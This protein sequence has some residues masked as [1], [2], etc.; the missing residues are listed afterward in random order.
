[1]S[2]EMPER[3]RHALGQLDLAPNAT[4]E[5]AK[6]AYHD[7]I[8]VWHPDKFAGRPKLLVRATQKTGQLNEA[9]SVLRTW[10]DAE[11]ERAECRR[12]AEHTQAGKDLERQRQSDAERHARDQDAARKRAAEGAERMRQRTAYADLR[13]RDQE[14]YDARMDQ[15][16]AAAARRRP[17][18]H[19][20][21]APSP[22]SGSS[23]RPNAD[24]GTA[25]DTSKNAPV[26]LSEAGRRPQRYAATVFV[27]ALGVSIPAFIWQQMI[28]ERFRTLASSTAP[29]DMAG[30]PYGLVAL[31]TCVCLIGIPTAVCSGVLTLWL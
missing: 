15:W 26:R 10:F 23:R 22:S 2:D 12:E 18:H 29:V 27:L 11:P 3:I 13:R 8:Q 14:A 21:N 4:R 5:E 20:T 30:Y 9:W 7:L 6:S 19:A 1:M 16:H 17:D 31:L 25:D 24:A 28:E